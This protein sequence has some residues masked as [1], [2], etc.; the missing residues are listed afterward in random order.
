VLAPLDTLPAGLPEK[1]LG[2]GVLDWAL[3]RFVQPDGPK[4]KQPFRPTMRQVR[5]LLWWYAL[6]DTGEFI[7]RHGVRRLAKGS[8]KARAP[9]LCRSVSSSDPFGSR[10]GTRTS[11]AAL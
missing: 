4:A 9:L 1:T 7:F 5:F 10:T 6:D 11:R 8:G 3:R 2:W